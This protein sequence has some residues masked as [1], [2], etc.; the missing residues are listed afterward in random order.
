[1]ILQEELLLPTRPVLP[2]ISAAELQCVSDATYERIEARNR[3]QRQ[4]A[5]KLEKI[6]K[7][8]HQT[9]DAPDER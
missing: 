6:I 2:S 4:H 8:T 5:E 7:S 9:R 3:L 1:M